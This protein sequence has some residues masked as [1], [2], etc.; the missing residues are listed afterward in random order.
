[1]TN[2]VTMYEENAEYK[3]VVAERDALA[4]TVESARMVC[5][6]GAF[7]SEGDGEYYV[8]RDD[9]LAILDGKEG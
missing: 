2:P 3:R 9:I 8:F 4:Q 7:L 5:M 1:M 6:D